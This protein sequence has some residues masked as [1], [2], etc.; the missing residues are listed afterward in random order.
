LLNLVHVVVIRE[1]KES[2]QDIVVNIVLSV[3]SQTIDVSP[4]PKRCELDTLLLK[5]LGVR[6]IRVFLSVTMELNHR[7]IGLVELDWVKLRCVDKSLFRTVV[8]PLSTYF[9][10][11]DTRIYTVST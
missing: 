10:Q 6:S 11:F 5:L 2:S 1:V 3:V 9:P 4:L 7:L 8:I